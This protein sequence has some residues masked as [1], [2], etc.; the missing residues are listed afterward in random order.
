MPERRR[1]E[2]DTL[3]GLPDRLMADLYLRRAFVTTDAYGAEAT[4]WDVVEFRGR[5]YR[6]SK[7]QSLADTPDRSAD[8][9]RATLATNDGRV[10]SGDEIAATSAAF[11]SRARVYRVEGLPFGDVGRAGEAHHYNCP[12]RLVEG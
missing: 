5:I 11:T 4:T 3:T 6:D 8:V 9:T 12:V 7:G 2:R 1:A 10:C